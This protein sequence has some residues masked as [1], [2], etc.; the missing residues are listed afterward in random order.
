MLCWDGFH[1]PALQKAPMPCHKVTYNA[2]VQKPWH[3]LEIEI[4]KEVKVGKRRGILECYRTVFF[5]VLIDNFEK[6]II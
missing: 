3:L 6:D 5:I 4:A 2:A 1:V